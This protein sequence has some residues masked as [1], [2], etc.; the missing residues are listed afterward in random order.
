MHG[1]RGVLLEKQAASLGL[2]LYQVFISKEATNEEYEMKMGEAFSVYRE[3]GINSIVFGDLFLADIRTYRDE[4]LA[5]HHLRGFYPVWQRNTTE[6][7]LGSFELGFKPVGTCADSK[8]VAQRFIGRVFVPRFWL[9]L[10]PYV[11][12]G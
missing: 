4:F 12:P 9:H 8:A 3:H 11:I 10:P 6:F 1:V 7:I 2:P 5:K